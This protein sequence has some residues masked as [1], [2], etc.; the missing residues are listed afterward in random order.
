[1]SQFRFLS[2]HFK[3]LIKKR[4]YTRIKK[5]DKFY[6][7][8]NK[9]NVDIFYSVCVCVCVSTRVFIKSKYTYLKPRL[10]K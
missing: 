9:I 2:L 7:T 6:V 4:F 3:L 8:N 5:R 10:N 1:M